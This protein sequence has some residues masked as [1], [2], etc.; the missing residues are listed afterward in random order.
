MMVGLVAPLPRSVI[1]MPA[2]A[3]ESKTD[4]LTRVLAERI[5]DGTYP[6]GSQL[7]SGAQLRAEFGVSQIVV[8]V[9]LARL[10]ERGVV[11]T[12]FGRGVYVA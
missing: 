6:S 4:M 3:R 1:T 12:E 8:R 2:P 11:V 7:P 10:K 5:A 9:A